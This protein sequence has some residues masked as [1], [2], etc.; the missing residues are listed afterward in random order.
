MGGE[1]VAEQEV[2][3]EE[4]E[5]DWEEKETARTLKRG[6]LL[7]HAR[8]G[9]MEAE[10]LLTAGRLSF[11]LK[12]RHVEEL[13]RLKELDMGPKKLPSI[14]A[15]AKQLSAVAAT[16]GLPAQVSMEKLRVVQEEVMR[17]HDQRRRR[18]VGPLPAVEA[19]QDKL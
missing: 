1:R 14:Q 8:R 10:E 11:P 6:K 4:E 15:Q 3:E 9:V 19:Q 16:S 18:G 2:H 12:P 17:V 7:M 13:R 5:E